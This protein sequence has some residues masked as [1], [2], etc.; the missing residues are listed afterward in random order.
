MTSGGIGKKELSVNDTRPKKKFEFLCAA[1]FKHFLYSVLNSFDLN[2]ILRLIRKL[3]QYICT[4]FLILSLVIC[5]L[6]DTKGP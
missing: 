4:F 2:I 6:S 5:P 3:Y 1:K